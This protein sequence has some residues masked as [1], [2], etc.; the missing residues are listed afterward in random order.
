MN[1]SMRIERYIQRRFSEPAH[2]SAGGTGEMFEP[3]VPVQLALEM[4]APDDVAVSFEF[5]F[6]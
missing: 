4:L 6:L 1:A 2:G 3:G 5:R